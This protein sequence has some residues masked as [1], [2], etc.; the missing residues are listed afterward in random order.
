MKL[1][2]A[3]FGTS[4]GLKFLQAVTGAALILF[5]LGHATGNLLIFLGPDALN[6][7]AKFLQDNIK[8]LWVARIGLLVMFVT[9][10][11]VAIKLKAIN[12]AA[13][14]EAY[15][16]E[17]TLQASIGSLSMTQSGMIILAFVIIHILHFTLGK[18]QP[19][20][21]NLLDTQGRHDVYSMVIYG[22]QNSYYAI[23][24]ILAMIFLGLH[25]SH[26]FG[27]LFQT[28]GFSKTEFKNNAKKMGQAFGALI[29][30]VYISI[31]ASVLF[32]VLTL[33][34]LFK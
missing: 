7:Y 30:L 14:P 27:S 32:G 34:G 1:C 33:E 2:K 20:Y 19:E 25:L 8:V 18:L 11:L 13:R 26:G 28:L 15:K 31:P 12:S 29:A 6:D 3:L 24:Y 16:K 10:I 23:G 9:H 17:D 4:I 5:V 22:F 21:A